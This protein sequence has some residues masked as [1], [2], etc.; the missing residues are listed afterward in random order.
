MERDFW[1]VIESRHSFNKILRYLDT[2]VA[3]GGSV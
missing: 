1:T 3:V 2:L